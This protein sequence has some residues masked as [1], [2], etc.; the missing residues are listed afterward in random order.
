MLLLKMSE[1]KKIEENS[2][3]IL[4]VK[5]ISK[6]FFIFHEKIDSV[7]SLFVSPFKRKKSGY[8]VFEV[9]KHINLKLKKGETLGVVGRNGSGKSTLLKI[10]AGIYA[11]DEGS[12]EVRGKIVPFLELGVGFNQDLTARENIF[13]NGTILGMTKKEIQLKFDQ[14]VDFAEI[15][16]FLDTQVKKF[17]SGMLVRL[18]FSIAIQ[19]HG[20]IYILDEV[21]AVGDMGFQ[22][23][24]KKEF[25]KL[26]KQGKSIVFVSHSMAA[27][28]E[29]C[30][31]VVCIDNGVLVEGKDVDESIN[32]YITKNNL[33]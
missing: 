12:I 29:F 31:R 20:D 13:L 33:V 18:A 21:L 26:K 17:S 4:E 14:I 6:N 2:D 27:I 25:L 9:L 8:D 15:R 19:A 16:D 5:N 24:S 23:K 10:I 7:K 22:E 32:Y 3:Y 30:D 1:N 28:K 11:P